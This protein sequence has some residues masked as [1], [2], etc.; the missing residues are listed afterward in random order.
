MPK[1]QIPL[2][3]GQPLPSDV[4]EFLARYFRSGDLEKLERLGGRITITVTA[5]YV[6]RARKKLSAITVDEAFLH[7]LQA[8]KDRPDELKES[9]ADL[10]VAE[11]RKLSAM[12]GLPIR[13][14]AN[15]GSI[16]AELLTHFGAARY[17]QRISG[18]SPDTNNPTS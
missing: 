16:R 7:T 3:A 14:R 2:G 12:V 11:L 18:T 17:W 15:A 13:S 8:L 1:F 10:S 9:L 4:K 5:P 6:D